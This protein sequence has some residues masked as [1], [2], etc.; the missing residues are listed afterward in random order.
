MNAL[1]N[2]NRTTNLLWELLNQNNTFGML[3]PFIV[4]C[5]GDIC[6]SNFTCKRIVDKRIG[7]LLILIEL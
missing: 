5:I 7:N 2:V 6:D 4:K 1:G 3:K